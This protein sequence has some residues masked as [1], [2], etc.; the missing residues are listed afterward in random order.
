MPLVQVLLKALVYSCVAAGV[1]AS[2]A[3]SP[4][5]L[6]SPSAGTWVARRAPPSPFAA[7]FAFAP[8]SSDTA[9][10]APLSIA[11]GAALSGTTLDA[12]L[13]ESSSSSLP[14]AH[15]PPPAHRLPRPP[16]ACLTPSLAAVAPRAPPMPEPFV[17]PPN[18]SFPPTAPFLTT[19]IHL[20]N[21]GL[22]TATQDRHTRGRPPAASESELEPVETASATSADSPPPT[23]FNVNSL[24][25][26]RLNNAGL[27]M[28][29]QD[30]LFI[31][32]VLHTYGRP[33]A[34]SE[35]ELEPDET[36]SKTELSLEED[37]GN[38]SIGISVTSADFIDPF[39]TED[40]RGFNLF[41]LGEYGNCSDSE[42][43]ISEDGY[44]YDPYD[45]SP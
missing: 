8:L 19:A 24:L 17:A 11:G 10:C 13:G 2:A 42:Q 39:E 27:P 35:S 20:N 4:G 25:P 43:S 7:A 38:H 36:A 18:G 3:S 22:P 31:R 29:L 1:A 9:K 15:R 5:V 23:P 26:S 30:S 44:V 34:A 28:A 45:K 14:P 33:P 37:R 21:A 12:S 40:R 32:P 16:S 41:M 6:L